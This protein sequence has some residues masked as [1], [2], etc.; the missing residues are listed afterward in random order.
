[1]PGL[2]LGGVRPTPRCGAGEALRLGGCLLPEDGTAERAPGDG[3]WHDDARDAAAL[4]EGPGRAA[5]EGAD[6]RVG[7]AS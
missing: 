7:E 2:P 4:G 6:A 5:R 3:L 1:L